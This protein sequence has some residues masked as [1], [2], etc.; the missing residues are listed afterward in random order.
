[1]KTALL[2]VLLLSDA[3]VSAHAQKLNSKNPEVVL[4]TT[5]GKIVISLFP[6]EAPKTVAN[7]LNYV[8]SGQYDGTI[9]HRVIP[10]F[11]IQ[12]G[13]FTPDFK[14]KPTRPPIQNEADNGLKNKRGS[15]AMARTGEPHSATTQFF[16]NTTD[17]QFLDH[18]GKNQK[19]WGYAVFGQVIEGMDV[20][21]AISKV[22]TGAQGMF[23]DVPVE[24]VMIKNVT[25][26]E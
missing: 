22:K 11:M 8:K 13:G 1:M 23:R 7:F 2:L 12:G 21:D 24:P 16:L 25:V 4:D 15:V 5:M 6:A 20:V 3:G 9:F 10:N 14:Q 26:R 17:N 19:G 18:K